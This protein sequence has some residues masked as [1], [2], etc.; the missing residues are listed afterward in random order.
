MSAPVHLTS[1]SQFV[2][3]AA[4]TGAMADDA[5]P[6]TANVATAE[7]ITAIGLAQIALYWTATGTPLS[8]ATCTLQL[9][10]LDDMGASPAQY[11]LIDQIDHV[12]PN[13]VVA[14][15][16][17][18]SSHFAV[19]IANVRNVTGLTVAK[20][21]GFGV[22]SPDEQ[23]MPPSDDP[24]KL[25]DGDNINANLTSQTIG[26]RGY[27]ALS[28]QLYSAADAR[29]G[30]ITF[31]ARLHPDSTTWVPVYFYNSVGAVASSLTVTPASDFDEIVDLIIASHNEFRVVFT[32]S[33]TGAGTLD[34]F[35]SRR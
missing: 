13:R 23:V 22:I 28:F 17:R 25:V 11:R 1:D 24:I 27:Q 26:M 32:D 2:E 18:G 15:R 33:A 34:V 9:W 30:T 20:I 19:R 7:I 29:G 16:C 4:R 8:L 6:T 5:A 21:R 31:E 14:L 10:A 35:A 3:L 12:R